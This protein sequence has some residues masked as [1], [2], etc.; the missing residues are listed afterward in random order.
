[1]GPERVLSGLVT[2]HDSA[3]DTVA[4]L[5]HPH[6]DV[7]ANAHRLV[8]ESIGSIWAMGANIDWKEFYPRGSVSKIS[9]PTYPFQ[10][11]LSLAGS[12]EAPH[13]IPNTSIH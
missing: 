10:K 9:L 4:A 2:Q 11:I 1:M 6:E 3:R 13:R 12:L 8:L 7:S 5:Y